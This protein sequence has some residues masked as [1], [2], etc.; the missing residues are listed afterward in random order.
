ML[1]CHKSFTSHS[2]FTIT[3]E[4]PSVGMMYQEELMAR[5]AR[6]Q[7]DPQTKFGLLGILC[8]IFCFPCGLLCLCADRESRCVRC[9]VQCMP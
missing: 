4:K 3:M 8:A 5:C 2:C 6:G 7:H 1:G 9:G